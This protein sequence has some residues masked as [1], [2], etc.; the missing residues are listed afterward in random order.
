MSGAITPL[1]SNMPSWGG[2]Q[3]KQ[4]DNF[5]FIPYCIVIKDVPLYFVK[6]SQYEILSQLN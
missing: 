4:R 2:A 3:F 1:P 5:T 6:H